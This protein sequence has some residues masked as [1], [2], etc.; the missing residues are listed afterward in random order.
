MMEKPSF[1]PSVCRGN[2]PRGDSTLIEHL[3]VFD[4]A[5]PR[6]RGGRCCL[7]VESHIRMMAAAQPF[8]SGRSQLKAPTPLGPHPTSRAWQNGA[9][10]SQ[11]EAN[12]REARREPSHEWIIREHRLAKPV[13]G[14]GLPQMRHSRPHR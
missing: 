5:N 12:F 11:A 2:P 6:G 8:I 3:A 13:D 14:R 7:W 4:C 10:G 1:N 9:T